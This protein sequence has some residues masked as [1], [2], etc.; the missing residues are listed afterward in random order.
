MADDNQ[1]D[2]GTDKKASN[3]NVLL[4]IIIAVLCTLLVAGGIVTAILMRSNSHKSEETAEVA[5]AAPKE[6][7][8]KIKEK[9]KE[10]RG[11][12][13]PAIYIAMEPPFVVNFE[14]TQQARFLQVNVQLMT[15]DSSTSQLLRD[16]EPIVRNDL[17]FLL[18]SQTYET[19]STASG[20]DEL[21]KKALETVRAVLKQEGG[22]PE[23]LEAVYFTSFVMQ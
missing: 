11:D 8:A 3:Q 15:R 23:L 19:V 4:I 17:L 16:N 21:R 13:G 10:K 5:E 1:K 20:K 18:S 22:K 6:A 2:A 7:P 9:E 12:K 14:A